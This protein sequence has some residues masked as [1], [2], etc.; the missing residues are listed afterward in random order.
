MEDPKKKEGPSGVMK[1]Y[2]G[3]LKG[4]PAAV[5]YICHFVVISA[6]L[7]IFLLGLDL[8]GNAFKG[9]SG[10]SVGNM[11]GSI[12]NP[13]AGLGL[14]VLAT[15]L[16]QSSS[17]TTSIVVTMVG[18]DILTVANSIPIIMGANIGTSVTNA[19]VSHGHA[20][21]RTPE[22]RHE[23]Q[24]GF[25]GAS[26]HSSFNLLCVAVL[27]PLELIVN[28]ITGT[29][30]ILFAI[31]EGIADGLVGSS[32]ET[33][34]SP[35]KILVGP[36]SSQF[37]KINKDLIKGIAKGCLPCV[38][39]TVNATE[40]T[41]GYCWD[42]SRK[43]KEGEKIKECV[44]T[45]EWESIYLEGD[46]V[47]S[48]LAA[49]MGDTAGSVVVLLISLI[50][51]CFALY[52]IVRVLHYLV[53]S[54]GR[55]RTEDG[56]ETPFI[57]AVR[58]VLGFNPYLSIFF[59]MV[60]TICVQSSSITTSAL[61]PLVALEI[62]S[63]EQMLPLTLG[64]NIG[65][66]CTAFLASLVTEKKNAIQIALVHFFFNI[67]GIT[68]WFPVPLMRAVPLKMAKILGDLVPKYR[69]FGVFYILLVFAVIP[70]LLFAYSFLLELG[71]GGIVVNIILDAL[72]LIG[73]V[74]LVLN[75]EKLMGRCKVA[76][77]PV[78]EAAS[79]EPRT[80]I[81]I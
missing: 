57:K 13:L 81:Q 27:L 30:G 54:A 77:E 67:I 17:T 9:L 21:E 80:Q 44:S 65:T 22:A 53:L 18:A 28:A 37:I 7:Y 29:G 36:L 45:A 14:G 68:I 71:A 69:W 72:T 38:G 11:L 58:M 51:L 79:E 43:D 26:A 46:I 48:G 34:K 73:A 15:V 12:D 24:L 63:V 75:F 40:V 39:A 70:L 33:F 60:M 1:F 32:V 19:I 3:A 56:D 35:V 2:A 47:K 62:I 41:D 59:G 42:N 25:Q 66:T 52:G 55:M 31:S 4:K 78:P 8:M 49:E 50:F 74:L 76:K 16:L 10:K 64:A 6:L 20:L 61:V 5:R 23:F